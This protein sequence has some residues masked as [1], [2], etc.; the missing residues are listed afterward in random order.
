MS[1]PV[2]FRRVVPT[3]V[4]S[5]LDMMREMYAEDGGSFAAVPA[6]RALRLL[7]AD[8]AH[9][10]AWVAEDETGACAYA[11]LTYGFSLEFHGRDAFVDEL[12]VRPHRR[13]QGLARAGLALMEAECRAHGV[14]ALH[15]EVTPTN[16]P[17]VALYRRFGFAM[18]GRQLMSKGL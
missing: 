3:D 11:V 16:E 6:E 4:P 1:L 7:I 14:H 8:G 12:F 13:G 9:G 17:A 10:A 2:R 5:V 15:L 18:R